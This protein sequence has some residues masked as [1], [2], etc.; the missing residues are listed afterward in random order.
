MTDIVKREITDPFNMLDDNNQDVGNNLERIVKEDDLSKEKNNPPQIKNEDVDPFEQP[1]VNKEDVKKEDIEEEEI[2]YDVKLK[3]NLTKYFADLMKNKGHLPSDF[4]IKE[5]ITEE[6]LNEAYLKFKEEPLKN[7]LLTEVKQKL[8]EEEGLSD[9]MLREIKLKH[10]GVQDEN[11]Q[12]LQVLN[13]FSNHEFDPDDDD[14]EKDARIFLTSY[15]GLKNL[16]QKRVEDFVNR[17]LEDDNLMDIIEEAQKEMGVEYNTLKTSI[18][19]D[20]KAK[21]DNIEK[22][23]KETK[24]KVDS[25]LS[26]GLINNIQYTAEETSFIKKA[27]FDKTEIVEI[28]GKSYRTTLYN[29]KKLEAKNNIELD[30][31][32]K[33]LFLLSDTSKK[34]KNR[35]REKV[36]RNMLGQ[37][38]EFVDIE[39][40]K[41]KKDQNQ[42]DGIVRKLVE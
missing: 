23:K 19:N 24:A 40:K 32:E 9:E 12:K 2:K 26:K 21:A 34:T 3:G 4:E 14:Y 35:E 25:L 17:D 29:K 5:N 1:I 18:E 28:D 37:L 8:A 22:D 16:N 41:N 10:Y 42:D 31:E 15:Y 33:I 13:Y 7:Q 30:L 36:T 27:L 38:N 11:I 39:I 20:I 6:E